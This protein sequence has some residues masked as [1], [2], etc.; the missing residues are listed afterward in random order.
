MK[1][2]YIIAPIACLFFFSSCDSLSPDENGDELG[3]VT[4]ND[5]K[6]YTT[7]KIG[8]QWWMMENLKET[9]YRNGDAI[10]N[11]TDDT[12]WAGLSTGARCAYDNKESNADTYGYLY[13][14]YTVND[15]RNIAPDG[16]RVPT[17]DDWNKLVT[18]LG[19]GSVAGGKMKST[20]SHWASP[21]TGATNES[22]FST[23]PAGYR[24][25]NGFFALGS[26]AYFWSATERRMNPPTHAWARGLSC[27]RSHVDRVSG[28]KR[29]GRSV[30]LL[31]D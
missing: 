8:E 30:R 12:E 13:N 10:P 29:Y 6:T 16:W 26:R 14:W 25:S 9:Q 7:I 17:D 18:Y 3:T 11:V 15:S 28:N 4:G 23:L 21:N 22:G 2:F 19:G 24:P 1:F 31:R 27:D 5:G 20:T